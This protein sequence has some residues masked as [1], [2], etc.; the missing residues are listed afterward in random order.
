MI[1]KRQGLPPGAPTIA[2]SIMAGGLLG[3]LLPLG[4]TVMCLQFITQDWT[5]QSAWLFHAH[6]PLL[7]LIDLT[8]LA[9]ATL[10]GVSA[11]SRLARAA[12]ERHEQRLG[13]DVLTRIAQHAIVVAD[14][15]DRIIEWSPGAE[16]IFGYTAEEMR[17][18]RLT[19]LIAVDDQ[20]AFE[21]EMA[22]TRQ[23]LDHGDRFVLS[24]QKNDGRSVS[25]E[26]SLAVW[27]TSAGLMLGA[28]LHDISKQVSAERRLREVEKNW[29]DIAENSSD[30]LLLLDRS[31]T[32]IFANRGPL[33]KP[34]DQVIGC[35][36][37]ELV[38]DLAEVIEPALQTVFD[39]GGSYQHERRIASDGGQAHWWWCRFAPQRE[40]GDVVRAV[41][42][43]SDIGDR[44]ERDLA[45]RRLAGI[46]ER[47]MDAV[48]TTDQNGR[49]R[50]WNAGAEL[51]WGW[52]DLEVLGKNLAMLCPP[53]LLDEQRIIFAR[54]RDGR[55]VSAYHAFGLAKNRRRIPVSVSVAATRN[56]TGQFEGIS[57]VVRDMSH[58]Q[59][60]QD[61]LEKAK[62]VAETANQLKSEFLANMSHEVRTPLN[63]VVGMVDLLR[64]T[65][66]DAVQEGYVSTL[67]EATQALR[68][69][70]DDVL[71]FSKIEAGQL[72]IES[73]EFDVLPLASSA[74]EMFRSAAAENGTELRLTLP[75][76]ARLRG[77][78]N[79]IRQVLINLLHN[80]VKF[81][82]NGG[83]DLRLTAREQG[84]S[85]VCLRFE[86]EDS[87]VG[88]GPEAQSVIFQ[89][90]SQ[91]DGSITRRFGGTGLGLSICRKLMDLMG[92]DIG[93]RSTL[94]IGS[95]FWFQ[96]ELEKVKG[97]GP[98][99]RSLSGSLFPKSDGGWKILVAEDNAINQK[100]VSAMLLGLG[101]SVDV[102]QNGRD[103]VALWENGAYDLILMDCQ[104]PIM[105]G[106]EATG[107][108]RQREGLGSARIPIVAMTAQAYAHDRERCTRAGM[109]DHLAKPL[110]KSELQSTLAKWLRL[111]STAPMA[112]A[113]RRSTGIAIDSQ[114]LERLE[115]ELGD[116][117]QEMLVGLI[118][119]FLLDLGEAIERL[120]EHIKAAEWERIA[121]EAHRLRSSTA[122]LAAAELSRLCKAMEQCGHSGDPSL[123]AEI[124]LR[125]REEFPR[126]REALTAYV[127]RQPAR[128]P[129]A[130]GEAAKATL[131]RETDS[132]PS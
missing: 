111:E 83:V 49:I 91:G 23:G 82:R 47:T 80:A 122:N 17:G 70:V 102:A 18:G 74:I 73:I 53:E 117:G 28:V 12:L 48:L 119:T 34:L 100:V 3:L 19:R 103:A 90:F 54:L 64:G 124:L 40:D 41:L 24:G 71:D 69:I 1:E 104:M 93:F 123:A 79:R 130:S 29:R 63:G 114:M 95:T 97:P 89:P 31:S 30:V 50:S 32:I 55:H 86:V 106:F 59:E 10:S 45:L 92:G 116:G 113:Q 121:F 72:K 84:E 67:L 52:S 125:L 128:T 8:P 22:R 68:V 26:I 37:A 11:R 76:P 78:P 101:C 61:A 35:S 36:V 131:T 85:S 98:R 57:A 110:T 44:V 6:H 115:S 105:S 15:Q 118:Q 43:I 87:G 58:H 14:A 112:P 25:L 9:T 42:S 27:Q 38:P 33:N 94:G 107:A 81:T 108:I 4:A 132:V 120:G 75:Q 20:G 127:Q 99:K 5:A 129:D 7:W 13:F 66:L 56:E 65:S 96:V 46:I 88:I 109:D 39:S 2:V 21:T 77:D 62:G 16:D 51:L 60:L 126:V